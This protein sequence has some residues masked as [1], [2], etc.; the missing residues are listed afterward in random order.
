MS[1]QAEGTDKYILFEL[2]GTSYGVASGRVRQVEMV[3]SATPGGAGPGES[4]TAITPVPNAPP[5][6]EGVV[7]S[8][9]QVI[10]ALSLRARF[11]LPPV[12]HELRT[13]LIVVNAGERVVGLIVD[14][15]REF[16][17][18]PGDRLQPPPEA[19]VQLAGR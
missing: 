15:A 9:G 2:A 10:P 7:L 17:S 8:R 6:V 3:A 16:V 18:I 19:L 14:A 12:P 5:Y 1:T 11:G 4:A 13:R